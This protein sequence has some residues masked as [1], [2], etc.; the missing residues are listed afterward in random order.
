[1]TGDITKADLG[2]SAQDYSACVSR[3][4]AVYHCA[5]DVRHFGHWETSYEVNTVGTQHVINL[6]LE[7]GAALHHISTMSVNGFI[8]TSYRT[9][10]SDTFSENNLFVG[11]RFRENIY[12]HSKYLA[13]KAVLNARTRGLRANIYRVGN[14]LWRD[15][16]G[17]F[18]QNNEAHD[19]YMLTHAFLKLQAVPEEF[20]DLS[21]DLTAVDLCAEAIGTLSEGENGMVYHMMN[22]NLTTLLEYLDS[23]SNKRIRTISL[24]QTEQLLRQDLSDLR[25]GFLLSYLQA[26]KGN[27]LD[28]FPQQLCD[29]TVRK[30]SQMGFCWKVPSSEYMRYVL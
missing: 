5:A 16:D 28:T 26:N 2:M 9:K 6:C 11:Q 14:L 3:V 21:F 23:I 18:Q 13:E 17:K 27:R 25:Y 22:P 4:A 8:L 15:S 24:D 7:A 30:L 19:F 20:C 10:I 12:V 1:V 29:L